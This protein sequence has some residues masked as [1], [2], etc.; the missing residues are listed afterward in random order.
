MLVGRSLW[1][2]RPKRSPDHILRMKDKKTVLARLVERGADEDGLWRVWHSDLPKFGGAAGRGRVRRGRGRRLGARLRVRQFAK[3]GGVLGGHPAA[4]LRGRAA[5]L[6]PATAGVS[7]QRS[8]R[9]RR[10]GFRLSRSWPI[11]GRGSRRRRRRF[12]P[13]GRAGAGRRAAHTS[14]RDASVS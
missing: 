2:V 9:R 5:P 7:G 6:L 1:R 12:R 11:R 3:A 4:K 10:E 13:Y 8:A 14:R